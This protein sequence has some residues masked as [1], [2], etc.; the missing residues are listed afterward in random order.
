MSTYKCNVCG[1]KK[2]DT[3]IS[4]MSTPNRCKQP[5]SSATLSNHSWVKISNDNYIKI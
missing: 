1:T 4:K 2:N 5:N 3:L